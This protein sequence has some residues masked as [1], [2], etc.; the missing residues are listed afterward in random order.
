[1][2]EGIETYRWRSAP[3]HLRTLR[4]LAAE[5]LRP[6]GQDIQGRIP[7]RRHG[8]ELVAHLFDVNQAAPKRTPTAAQ[9]AALEKATRAHQL[10]AAQRRGVEID[11]TPGDPGPAWTTTNESVNAFTATAHVNAFAAAEHD[12][13]EG[14]ER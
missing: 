3:A 2:S 1:M 6:N 11:Q 10:R 13:E 12:R 8:R 5:G 9:L 14:M 7:F 4:Q